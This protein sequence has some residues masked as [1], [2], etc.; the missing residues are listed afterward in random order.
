MQAIFKEATAN[1]NIHLVKAKRKRKASV[2][3]KLAGVTLVIIGIVTPVIMGDGSISVLILP[4]G[5]W[6][7]FTREVIM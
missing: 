6:L 1:G 2:M 7:I 4:L 5:L 3:Q